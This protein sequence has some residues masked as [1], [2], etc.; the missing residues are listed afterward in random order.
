MRKLL[1]CLPLLTA[2]ACDPVAPLTEYTPVVDPGRVSE[3]RFQAD[4]VACRN[5]ALQVEA[6]YK[7]KQ[8]KEMTQNLVAG[9]LVGALVGAAA[10]NNSG[11]QSDYVRAGALAGAS[12][13][14]A[15]GDYTYDL[16]TFGPRRVV[17][18]CMSGRGYNILSDI[19]RGQ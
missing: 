2:V 15:S 6:E 5:L 14:V 9:I 8:E 12:S 19:G 11:Y 4:L 17:D 1:L 18:R 16:V 10:G 3:A 13:A 7:A